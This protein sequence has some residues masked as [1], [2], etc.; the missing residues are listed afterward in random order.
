MNCI[1]GAPITYYIDES[2]KRSE[3][4]TIC[5]L[6]AIRTNDSARLISLIQDSIAKIISDPVLCQHKGIGSD[7]IPHYCNDHPI[8]IH[9]KLLRDIFQMPF[10]AYIVYGKKEKFT[11]NNEYDW[12]DNLL[13]VLFSFRLSADKGRISKIIFEQHGSKV[14]SREADIKNIISDVN[15]KDALKRKT[16][17]AEIMVMSAGKNVLPLCLPD[18]IGGSFMSHL[19]NDDAKMLNPNR[20]KFELISKK[21]RWIKDIDSGVIYTSKRPF[22]RG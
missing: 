11:S 17:E 10:E 18:Y 1:Y 19:C 15:R 6:T 5:S 4:G 14:A 13:R 21:V 8:E 12:Y 2:L 20:R 3:S 22:F 16:M 9:D 7:F